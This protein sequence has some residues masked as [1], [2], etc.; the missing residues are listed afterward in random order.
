LLEE[1]GIKKY[2]CDQGFHSFVDFRIRE[3]DESILL[4]VPFEKVADKVKSGFTSVR[5]LNNFKNRMSQHFSANVKVMFVKSESHFDLEAGFLQ[6]LNRR[7]DN[8]VLSLYI[9][10]LDEGS[11][12]IW[13]EVRELSE[14]L[15]ADISDYLSE[16]LLGVNLVLSDIQWVFASGDFPTIPAILRVIKVSQPVTLEELSNNLR[17]SYKVDKKW[18]LNTLDNLR[19]KQMLHW[20]KPGTYTLTGSSLAFVPA[21]AR[22]SSSDIDRALAL[23]RRKW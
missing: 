10:F 14:L 1:E 23:A 8:C 11:V 12:V 16:L 18:L 15:K 7:Y 2:I 20:Q 17:E 13:L 9:S 19:K 4:Y 22:R 3:Y 5:Q 21:G 6:M